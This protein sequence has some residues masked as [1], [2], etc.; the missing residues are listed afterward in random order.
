MVTSRLLVAEDHEAARELIRKA[1]QG[2]QY[3]IEF[4]ESGT[5]ALRALEHDGFS[6][7][8]LDVSLP[9]VSGLE[10]CERIKSDPSLSRTPV[11]LMSGAL[12]TRELANETQR[13]HADAFLAKP[14]SLG[15]LRTTVAAF[16]RIYEQGREIEA[17]RAEVQEANLRKMTV[18]L[19]W[20]LPYHEFMKL[21]RKQYFLHALAQAGGNKSRLARSS[22]LDRSTLYVHFRNLGMLSPV[23]KTVLPQTSPAPPAAAK[24]LAPFG[25]RTDR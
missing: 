20:S 12:A 22:G 3:D 24:R 13:V 6:T 7:A 10:L 18:E 21:A 1:L 23:K 5:Q 4:A 9:G 2:G 14:F 19:D 25:S 15:E 8:L 11:I 17:L 16:S